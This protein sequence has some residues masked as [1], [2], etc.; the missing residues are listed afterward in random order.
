MTLDPYYG[1][2]NG[3]YGP[4]FSLKDDISDAGGLHALSMKPI[5][6]IPSTVKEWEENTGLEWDEYNRDNYY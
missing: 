3:A 1:D 5:S 2:R 6:S 4:M